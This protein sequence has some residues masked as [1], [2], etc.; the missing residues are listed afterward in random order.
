MNNRGKDI[1]FAVDGTCTW[2]LENTKYLEW[3]S[4]ESP[5]NNIL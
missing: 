5:E 2:F 4:S 1:E 3:L